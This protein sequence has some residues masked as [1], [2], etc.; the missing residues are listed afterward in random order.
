MSDTCPACEVHLDTITEEA[1]KRGSLMAENQRLLQI[2]QDLAE[3]EITDSEWGDCVFC[4]A[5]RASAEPHDDDCVW[6]RARQVA[7]PP[8]AETT[9]EPVRDHSHPL[10]PVV[11]RPVSTP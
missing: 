11:R 6:H 9:T 3:C 7:G 5:D 2:I 8:P 1:K 4:G 10:A